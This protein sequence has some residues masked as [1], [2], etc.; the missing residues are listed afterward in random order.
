MSVAGSSG[1]TVLNN[2]NVGIGTA[3][4]GYKM[5]VNGT[6]YF[7]G[8]LTVSNGEYIKFGSDAGILWF[9]S[10]KDLSSLLGTGHKF[11]IGGS[12]VWR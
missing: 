1:L 6:S 4:P 8:T 7:A 10:Q 3:A 11:V 5:E 2:G 12:L 9:N